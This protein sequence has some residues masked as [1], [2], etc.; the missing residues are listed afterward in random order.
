MG[1]KSAVGPLLQVKASVE[2]GPTLRTD[3]GPERD[4]LT[5]MNRFGNPDAFKK[6]SGLVV[7]RMENRTNRQS[8]REA[9]REIER[10]H[11]LKIDID[12]ALDKNRLDKVS[13]WPA[14]E[15]TVA[16]VAEYLKELTCGE[17]LLVGDRILLLPQKKA[18]AHWKEWW[19]GQGFPK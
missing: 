10:V 6:L 1:R 16:P 3:D 15:L 12:E 18:Y 8:R 13:A 4:M 14:R 7:R 2:K 17:L 9:I 19:A 11:G 5:A